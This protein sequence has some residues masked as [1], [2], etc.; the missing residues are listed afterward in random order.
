MCL[1]T[2]QSCLS[3]REAAACSD[4][5]P[6]LHPSRHPALLMLQKQSSAG[7][8]DRDLHTLVWLLKPLVWLLK[9]LVQQQGVMEGNVAS[10]P[11]P[12]AGGLEGS[13][14]SSSSSSRQRL[15]GTEVN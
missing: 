8:G 5:V 7:G 12:F 15:G 1:P 10:L 9:P 13:G 14:H 2:S 11:R 3:P 6:T 4:M